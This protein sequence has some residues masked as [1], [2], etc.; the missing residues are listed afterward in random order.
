[1][2][3]FVD[4]VRAAVWPG[5]DGPPRSFDRVLTPMSVGLMVRDGF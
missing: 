3:Q 4:R 2:S 1:M 5:F